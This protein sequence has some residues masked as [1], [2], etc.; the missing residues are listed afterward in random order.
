VRY[1]EQ[2]AYKGRR[3]SA[4]VG[5]LKEARKRSNLVIRTHARVHR[6][7]LKG[8]RCTG[9]EYMWQGQLRVANARHE[10]VLSAGAIQSPQLLELSGIGQRDRLA[11]LGI[12]VHHDLPAVGEHMS[13]HLQVRCTYKTRVPETIND[14]MNSPWH[15]LRAGMSYLFRRK[16]LLAGTS[17]TAHAIT[18]S[19]T[20]ATH[21]DVMIRIYH[22]SGADRYSRSKIAGMDPWSGF[23]VGGFM[24]YPHSRG[25]IHCTSSDPNAAPSIQPNYLSDPRDAQTTVNMLRLIREIADQPRMREVVIEENRPGPAAMSDEALLEYAKE[26][27]QTAWHTVGTCRMG[28][29]DSA[30]VDSQ[31]RVHGIAG[32]RVADASVMPTIASSNTNAPSIMI[33]ERAADMLLAAAK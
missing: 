1:L 33:G 10:V 2:T 23:S 11:A 24:L 31:L 21:P 5:Y 28:R 13:D 4:A 26:I 7:L 25:S 20:A 3:W 9:V 29:P 30:V 22:I 18:R 27:G 8:K 14:L 12:P 17:S 16:G 32:L 19:S 6:V 15:K